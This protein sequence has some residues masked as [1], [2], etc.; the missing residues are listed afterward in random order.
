MKSAIAEII[1]KDNGTEDENMFYERKHM[2]KRQER[3][4]ESPKL[5][6]DFI[7][8]IL[9]IFKHHKGKYNF[10]STRT[11]YFIQYEF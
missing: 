3:S 10:K 6:K 9:L 8:S 1:E 5:K 11:L 4:F 7:S 2:T